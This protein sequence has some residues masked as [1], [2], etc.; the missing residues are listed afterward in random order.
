MPGRP[1]VQSAAVSSQCS[2]LSPLYQ[3]S[4]SDPASDTNTVEPLLG[5]QVQ[6]QGAKYVA[7]ESTSKISSPLADSPQSWREVEEASSPTPWH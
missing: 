3:P 4:A 1:A 7:T 6:K 2:S 5:V